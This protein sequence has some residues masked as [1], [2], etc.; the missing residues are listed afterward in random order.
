MSQ[1]PFLNELGDAL[2]TAIARQG[3][4]A[5]GRGPRFRGRRHT[6]VFAALAIAVLGGGAAVAATLLNT[7]Q[8]LADGRVNCYYSTAPL[9]ALH[10][11]PDRG[12]GIVSGDS[13]IAI[14]RQAFQSD[15]HFGNV[16]PGTK[17][18]PHVFVACR[19]T[20]TTVNVYFSDGRPAQC[21]RLKQSPLPLTYAAATRQLK[22][23]SARLATI[24]QH[25]G[26]ESPRAMAQQVQQALTAV[27]LDGW[28]ISV[29]PAQ[30]PA[31]W[32]V[33]P[34]GTGGTCGSLAQA[35]WVN[36]PKASAPLFSNDRV[37]SISLGPPESTA[38]RMYHAIGRLYQ[39]TYEHCYT[40]AS[41]R[42][43]VRRAFAPLGMQVRFAT[44]ANQKGTQYERA[45]QRLYERGCV[46]FNTA[47]PGNNNHY[48]DVL[49]IAKNAPQLPARQFYPPASAF[50]P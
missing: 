23:L 7:G 22:A 21:E 35:S 27:G 20:S 19:A 50:T 26:C 24:Q 9:R 16:P 45:S 49:L 34:A 15:M 33:G 43:L 14:C 39:E 32:D 12:T 41:V 42:P 3:R 17:P 47:Y 2:D 5:G 13:P 10:G 37:I 8:K 1:I 31:R 38:T 48:A 44:A 36:T 18:G 25:R 4:R 6:V 40:P 30:T 11:A 46:R 29:P 28:R